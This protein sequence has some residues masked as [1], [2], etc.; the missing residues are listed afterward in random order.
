M[1]KHHDIYSALRREIQDGRWKPGE[2]LPSEADLVE[3][4][5]VSRITIGRAVRDLQQADWSRGGWAP[6]FVRPRGGRRTRARW[7]RHSD[8]GDT[9]PICRGMMASPLAA[10]HARRVATMRAGVGGRPRVG[11]SAGSPRAPRVG[12]LLRA[13]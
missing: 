5:G 4:F 7:P 9:E 6:G 12:R 1:P 10:K 11:R 2:R 8:L 13:S 3:R